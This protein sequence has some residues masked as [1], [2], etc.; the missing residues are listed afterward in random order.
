MIMV[1]K[2]AVRVNAPIPAHVEF[3]VP[4]PRQVVVAVDACCEIEPSA[5]A[6]AGILIMPRTAKVDRRTMTLNADQTLHHTCW[7]QRPRNIVPAP[8]ALGELT[9]AYEQVLRG[10][11]SVLALHSPGRLDTAVQAALA[12]RSILLAGSYHT[13]EPAPRVA[14]YELG[15]VSAGFSF[16]VEV[17]A[18]GAA[19]GLALQQVL[20]LLDRVQAAL[21]C[22]YFTSRGG[23]SQAL[24]NPHRTAGVG[25]FG[26]EQLW[27]LDS[28]NGGLFTRCARGM[29]VT[30]DLFHVDGPL[31]GKQPT[32]VRSS[33]QRLLERVNQARVQMQ[34][35][36]LAAEP[37]GLGLTALFPRGCIELVMLPDETD[38]NRII[39]VIRRL[40]PP[41]PASVRGLRQRGGI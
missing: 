38:I 17:A 7:P 3:T 4:P 32:V 15:A 21:R 25:W 35:S 34:L 12:A 8:Y 1:D 2:P 10:G 6:H 37:G 30:R 16:L 41:K 19:Q 24:C 29:R 33:D 40:D 26:N 27:E 5:A 31:K 9:Q 20:T 18:C 14:V 28:A 22:Y 23:P 13:Q 36:P 39:E 11:L